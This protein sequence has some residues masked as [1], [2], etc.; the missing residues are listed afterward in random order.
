MSDTLNDSENQP[1]VSCD[2]CDRSDVELYDWKCCWL[3][4]DDCI[5]IQ[6]QEYPFEGIEKEQSE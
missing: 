5:P 1:M 2:F 3:I 6:M 4:C